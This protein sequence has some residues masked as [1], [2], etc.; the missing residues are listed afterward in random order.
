MLVSAAGW[1]MEPPVSVA[2]AAGAKRAATEAAD[3]PDE[4]PGERSRSHGFLTGPYQ[5]VS[6]DDPIANS[7]MLAL[8]SMTT[9]ALARR[10][11][12]VAS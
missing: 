9:P 8:P 4:P 3:P 7:S 2:V 6:F 12:M 10:S 1:R 5:L 11:T